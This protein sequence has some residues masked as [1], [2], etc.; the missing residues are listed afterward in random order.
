[1]LLSY[2]R[3]LV[4]LLFPFFSCSILEVEATGLPR[5]LSLENLRESLHLGSSNSDL[6]LFLYEDHFIARLQL[7][8]VPYLLRYRHLALC[9]HSRSSNLRH[10]HSY[11]QVKEVLLQRFTVRVTRTLRGGFYAYRLTLLTHRLGP[12][13]AG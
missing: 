11:R 5:F 3:R 12:P 10:S 13:I 4:Q 2:W 1:M 7:Q 8:R 6:V 9:A